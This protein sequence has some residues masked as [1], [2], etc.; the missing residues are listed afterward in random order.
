MIWQWRSGTWG[1][2]GHSR[3]CHYCRRHGTPAVLSMMEMTGE[4]PELVSNS[5][6]KSERRTLLTV[7]RQSKVRKYFVTFIRKVFTSLKT[8]PQLSSLPSRLKRKYFLDSDKICPRSRSIGPSVNRES[9]TKGVSLYF[10]LKCVVEVGEFRYKQSIIWHCHIVGT[11]LLFL[12]QFPLQQGQ[13]LL[14]RNCG[15]PTVGIRRT[16]CYNWQVKV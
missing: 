2:A 10:H 15:G 13:G 12:R 16:H 11:L 9:K 7:C 6:P 14:I 1:R 4:Y 8:Y 5:D 3:S